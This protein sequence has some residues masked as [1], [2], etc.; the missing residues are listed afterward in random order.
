M[1]PIVER[2]RAIIRR[3]TD[4]PEI[5]PPLVR[6]SIESAWGG[7]PALVY[8]MADLDA[9]LRLTEEWVVLGSTHLALAR[10]E[11]G[12]GS[13]SIRLM[14][15]ER[16]KKVA[17]VPGLSFTAVHFLSDPNEP[18]LAVVRYSARQRGPMGAILFLLQN[19]N[20]GR[21]LDPAEADTFYASALA[22]PL[23]KT[24]SSAG[25]GKLAVVRRL[26]SYLRPYR[27][28][29][30]IGLGSA[31][32]WTAF[33]LLPPYLT[34]AILD[35]A[36]LP[37]SR[38][39][40]AAS[41]A[42]SRG[43]WLLLA[44]L[45]AFLLRE[46]ALWIRLRTLTLVG[47][48]VARDLREHLYD[49]LHRLSVHFFS[50]NQTGSI[51]SRVSSDTDRIWDFIAFGVAEFTL[52]MLMVVGLG[53]VLLILDWRLGLIL[54]LPVPL[55]FAFL[56][57]MGRKLHRIFLRVWNKWSEMTAVL[58][59][60]IPGIR[61]VKA[62][63]R[64]DFERSRF[65]KRNEA[66]LTESIHILKV[67]TSHWPVIA[68][69]VDALTVI[70]WSMAI[71][72]LTGGAWPGLSPGTFVAFLLFLGMFLGPLEQFGFLTR[73]LNRSISSAHRVFEILD[74]EP[75]I[76]SKP[77][78]VRLEPLRGYIQFDNVIFGYDPVRQI[79]KGVS[80]EAAPG[81]MIGL[82]GPS[83]AGKTTVINLIARFYDINGGR[84]LVDGTPIADLELGHYREQIGMV[85]QD[86]YLFH[87]SILNNIRY[88]RQEA[89]TEEVVA[90]AQAAN[91]HDF[92]L[93]LPN[94]YDTVVG[95]RG[96][97][98]SGGERQRVSIARAILHNPRILILDEATSSVDT[99][100][101]RKIQEAID[102][103]IAGRTVFA[104]AHRLSTLRK[105]S[106][107]L[108]MKD[109]LIVESGTHEELLRQPE[110][111]YRRL[112]EMQRELHEMYAV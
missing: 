73:M 46:A 40:L 4:Q 108:V 33:S 27:R 66:V 110:G 100:T 93:K 25:R 50:K 42:A 45:G 30:F 94:G 77:D 63:N 96:H 13:P 68:L 107:L 69:V 53:V 31:S 11:P 39:Q 109:G 112:H 17:E 49:H 64:A 95:E 56:F 34:G 16:I 54:I 22:E 1:T 97:T 48:Y 101:E 20:T 83:G 7:G 60:T 105:A 6:R 98:L 5:I 91:A 80:F 10:N 28:E 111:L 52:S 102:R 70:V 104:I 51:I 9:S 57:W 82:V 84:L 88:G 47:E 61:V 87:G 24:Q 43:W 58:S 79:L 85:M 86:P 76:V 23:R 19:P 71:P 29:F 38:G 32:L 81:E 36:L 14:E 41:E 35:Q 12:R 72:R 15:R 59:D 44:I 2:N 3:Y 26:L 89:S 75:D 92:I 106:R 8:A 99:E 103:L 21:N 67:W 65:N 62:F 78:A 90:A 18:A 37:Y 74:T 55:V